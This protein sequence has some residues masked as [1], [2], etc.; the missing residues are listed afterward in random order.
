MVDRR[1]QFQIDVVLG[2]FQQLS[3]HCLIL[4]YNETM[5]GLGRLI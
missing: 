2:Q 1:E 3:P 5:D 4:E